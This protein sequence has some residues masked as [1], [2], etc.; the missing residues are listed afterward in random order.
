MA[1]IKWRARYD[2]VE[3]LRREWQRR[4]LEALEV[5]EIENE[6]T[7]TVLVHDPK[8]MV[9]RMESS[10]EEMVPRMELHQRK[11]NTRDRYGFGSWSRGNGSENGVFTRGNSRKLLFFKW[12]CFLFCFTRPF[13]RRMLESVADKKYFEISVRLLVLEWMPAMTKTMSYETTPF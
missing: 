11:L 8:E 6:K 5:E 4:R 7:A 10:P 13:D 1:N 2:D 3:V 9:P 12:K